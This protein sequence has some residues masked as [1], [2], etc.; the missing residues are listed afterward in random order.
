VVSWIKGRRG[1][2]FLTDSNTLY[3][4]ERTNSVDHLL[5]ALK[6]GFGFTSVEAPIIISDGL[7]SKDTV[8]VEAGPK[9]FKTIK[10]GSAIHYADAL[11]VL[12]HLTGHLGTGMAGAIK[13][14]GMGAASRSAKQQM[15]ASVKPKFVSRDICTGCGTCITACHWDA[16]VVENGKARFDLARC[17]GC[18]ECIV[19][20]PEEALKI[21]WT[22]NPETLG[23]KIAEVCLAITKMKKNKSLFINFLTDV[24]P[25][26]D[27]LMT[28]GNPIVPNLGIL[29]STDPVALDRASV[30]LITA[31]EGLPGAGLEKREP[32]ADK[33]KA[34]RPHIEWFSQLRYGQEIGLGSLDFE[35]IEL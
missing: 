20:C 10:Y 34:L 14:V 28:S 5:C 2:P 19:T 12:T 1:K 8:E 23:E 7:T 6:N 25:D 26:C 3:H 11:V 22:E 16:V 15:H 24:T 21:L 18:G 17:A 30:D 27:C 29:A 33:F 9:Y 31:S 32:G 35:M 13:N 4:G